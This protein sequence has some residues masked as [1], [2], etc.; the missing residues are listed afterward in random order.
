[1]IEGG[2]MK[3]KQQI[4]HGEVD[5]PP[6]GRLDF[7]FYCFEDTGWY[8]V[9]LTPQQLL[10]YSDILV[11][12]PQLRL[13]VDVDRKNGEMFLHSAEIDPQTQSAEPA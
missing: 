9:Y 7:I 8:R 11:L 6:A 2:I 1:M 4:V 13:V 10:K 5:K 3:L 12:G